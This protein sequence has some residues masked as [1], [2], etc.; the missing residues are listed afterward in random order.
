[1]SRAIWKEDGSLWLD[2]CLALNAD[3]DLRG[4]GNGGKEAGKGSFQRDHATFN[5]GTKDGLGLR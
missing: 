1:M 5:P 3:K 2:Q 4:W